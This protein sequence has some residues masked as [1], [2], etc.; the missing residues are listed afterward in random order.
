MIKPKTG[1]AHSADHVFDP[2]CLLRNIADYR[3][4]DLRNASIDKI[5]ESFN[6]IS[7]FNFI[8]M[9]IGNIPVFRV[10]KIEK[11]D[12]H[13]HQN[14]IWA[15]PPEK[16]KTLGRVNQAG[17]SVFYAALDP[18]TA[19]RE[20]R[21]QP[22]DEFTLGQFWL[23]PMADGNNTSIIISIPCRTYAQSINQ[24]LCTMILNDFIFSE[25]TRQISVDTEFQYK[26][27]CAISKLL[28][29][30][31]Y[32]DSLIYPSMC[33]FEFYNIALK[34][35]S[36]KKRIASKQILNCR[37]NDWSKDG[38]PNITVNR[39]GSE[40]D[41]LG[42]IKYSKIHNAFELELKPNTFGNVVSLKEIIADYESKALV[43]S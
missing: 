19:V 26:A 12:K 22:G 17:E 6:L 15:P 41:E 8:V 10:R 35:D 42:N 7:I 33:D 32:K 13:D 37:L 38:F 30:L 16:V 27:T 5:I 40:L 39:A 14:D 20:V 11:G 2:E 9:N 4:I 25:F 23:S 29:E 24:R 31:P 21:L 43:T 1:M 36:A 34:H 3:S 28:L 18:V